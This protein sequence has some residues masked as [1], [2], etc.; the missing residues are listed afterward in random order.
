MDSSFAGPIAKTVTWPLSVK[1][2][3]GMSNNL[4]CFWIHSIDFK[5][6]TLKTTLAHL[7]GNPHSL[8]LLYAVTD[9]AAH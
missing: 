2:A 4:H 8:V 9:T 1:A 7:E 6:G 3:V 5:S